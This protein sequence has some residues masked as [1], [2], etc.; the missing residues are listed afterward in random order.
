MVLLTALLS[1]CRRV[2]L[3]TEIS[4][5]WVLD[6]SDFERRQEL[7]RTTVCQ[8]AKNREARSASRSTKLTAIDLGFGKQASR[9]DEG[10]R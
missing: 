6:L 5:S 7:G 10:S 9:S 1:E 3:E 4:P 2:A 8:G